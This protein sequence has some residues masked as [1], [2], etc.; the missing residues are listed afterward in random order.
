MKTLDQIAIE[1]G[2]DKSSKGHAYCQYY[3]M[4]LSHLRDAPIKLLEIGIDEGNSLRMW[5]QY[6]KNGEIHGIDIRE[7]Y[8]Y[9]HEL[10]LHT[11]LVDQSSPAQL[12][13]FAANQTTR[14]NICID[15]GSHQS[16]DMVMSFHALFPYLEFGGYYIIEDLLCAYDSRWSSGRMNVLDRIRDMIGEVNMNGAIPN[17]HICANKNEAVKKYNATYWG[18]NIEWV[19]AACGTV[20]IKKMP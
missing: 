1:C 12:T 17:S 10:G 8:E 9:L 7:G 18:L 13:N 4:M 6:F 16:D 19:F 14:F 11:H 2:T 20:I 5:Q 15:D 3:D